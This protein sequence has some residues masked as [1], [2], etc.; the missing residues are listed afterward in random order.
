LLSSKRSI[1]AIWRAFAPDVIHLNVCSKDKGLLCFDFLQRRVR[2]SVVMTLHDGYLYPVPNRLTRTVFGYSDAIVTVSE[3][4]RHDALPH[5]QGF[6]KKLRVIPN[7]LPDPGILPA[8]FPA[9]MR[10]LA[11]GRLVR[12]KGFD[13]ALEGFA[14]IAR[15]FPQAMLTIAGDGE[16]R[17]E[18]EALADAM[19]LTKRVEFLGWRPP[20]EIYELINRHSVVIMPSR[21]QEPFGLVALQAAQ[22]GRPVCAAKCGGLP[23]I[24]VEGKTGF[25]FE[26]GN[27]KDL[28]R[29]LR[30]LLRSAS[31]MESLGRCARERAIGHFD[32]PTFLDRYEA[33]YQQA[34]SLAP[35]YESASIKDGGVN[36]TADDLSRGKSA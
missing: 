16:V 27:A 34:A 14:Q 15:E 5:L 19:E 22:M 36:G 11:M 4:I 30:L 3:F 28:A 29:T 25:L 7:A 9:Q 24:V 6:E 17:S 10:F 32:Y 26:S 33:L 1:A 13:I 35:A 23:E 8:S 21:W 2:R 18:L 20:G 12:D 31:G